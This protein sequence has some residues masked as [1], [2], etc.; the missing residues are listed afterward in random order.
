MSE[1]FRCPG[2]RRMFRTEAGLQSHLRQTTR[3]RCQGLYMSS[4]SEPSEPDLE[5]GLA[6]KLGFE[7]SSDAEIL[8]EPQG[9]YFGEYEAYADDDWGPQ[10]FAFSPLYV[11]RES[12]AADPSVDDA[13]PGYSRY[14]SGSD[15]D[16]D[17]L[18][19]ER[20]ELDE[21]D[22][23]TAALECEQGWEP[24]LIDSSWSSRLSSPV[25]PH[26]RW[27]ATLPL[28]SPATSL[29][30]SPPLVFTPSPSGS[31]P[32]SR[33]S[34]P[35]MVLSDVD[36]DDPITLHSNPYHRLA[37]TE[38][39]ITRYSNPLAGTPMHSDD[40]ET[41]QQS[42]NDIYQA[43]LG[44]STNPYAPFL[45][46]IDWGVARWAKLRG[47]SSTAFSELLKIPGVRFFYVI[48]EWLC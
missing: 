21:L 26:Y 23:A 7:S 32:R 28:P 24:G 19:S 14:I 35:A 20:D 46:E 42:T 18:G 16:A 13:E 33:S 6:E 48:L 37:H 10:P 36:D 29:V 11:G 2:C 1:L 4:A 31:T 17:T 40:S 44:E 9:D 8:T 47:P 45:S 5:L 3:T 43:K 12:P 22:S 15:S 34:S 38:P 41:H 25:I 39:Y 27:D 30:G